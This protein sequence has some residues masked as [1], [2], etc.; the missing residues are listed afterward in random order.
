MLAAEMVD[1]RQPVH[2]GL[3]GGRG[4]VR[5]SIGQGTFHG[6]VHASQRVHD[7][8]KGIKADS[9]IVVRAHTEIVLDGSLEQSGASAGVAITLPV[10]VGS[11]DLAK[12][13]AGNPGV[14]VAGDGEER[15]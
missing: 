11:V 13:V 12:A 10:T 8:D 9:R 4:G 15:D 6:H 5:K 3:A 2:I 14:K 7:L 1:T